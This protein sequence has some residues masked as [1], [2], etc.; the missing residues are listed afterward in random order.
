MAESLRIL[1]I[2]GADL[3]I[4]KISLALNLCQLQFQL[5]SH[6]HNI[7][8]RVNSLALYMM[9]RREHP[10][11]GTL[12]RRKL[13]IYLTPT[14]SSSMQSEMGHWKKEVG[15]TYLEGLQAAGLCRPTQNRQATPSPSFLQFGAY[16]LLSAKFQEVWGAAPEWLLS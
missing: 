10:Q 14:N 6:L 7:Q 11:P 12:G 4:L 2:K 13:V 3:K 8:C 16:A 15:N 9:V 5:H 1:W